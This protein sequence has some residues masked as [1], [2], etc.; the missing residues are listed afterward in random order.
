M[1][2]S[3][4]RDRR[5]QQ[6]LQVP[7]PPEWRKVL[8][9][10]VRHYQYL[11]TQQRERLEQFVQ[12]LVAEKD[13]VGGSGFD[14]NVGMK[15]T[16]AGY[17]GVM[18]LGMI[19]PY[20]FDRLRTI[21][22]YPGTYQPQRSSYDQYQPLGLEHPRLGE[23]WHHG[24]IVLSWAEIVGPQRT[25]PGNN[26]VIHEFAHHVDGLDG[27]IDGSPPLVGREKSAPG[28]M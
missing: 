21:I 28:T 20:Y 19:E 18:T 24:P 4:I 23:S 5:R 9:L 6:I 22:V 13:W 2:F 3:W 26:L 8:D 15:V 10:L 17:A 12:V 25:R 7:F 27:E 14:L 11:S 16:I 1:I